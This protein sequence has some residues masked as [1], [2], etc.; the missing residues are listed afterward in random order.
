MNVHDSKRAQ[1]TA[2]NSQGSSCPQAEPAAVG[3]WVG[4]CKQAQQAAV[5]DSKRAQLAAVNSRTSSCRVGG[6]GLQTS[7][8]CPQAEPV[9]AN[10]H[11]SCPHAAAVHNCLQAE[12]AAVG[13]WV[14]G[15]KLAQLAAVVN[16]QRQQLSTSRTSSCR[17]GG[18]KQACC[19]GSSC[20]WQSQQLQTGA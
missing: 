20:P 18:Y 10:W 7:S 14:G 4:N 16:S 9:A 17:G 5:L 1:P 12:P 15:N 3:W 8:S 6:G 2:V 19:L 13:W 11:C